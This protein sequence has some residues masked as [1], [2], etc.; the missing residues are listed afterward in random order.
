MIY[1]EDAPQ[2]EQL[3]YDL[4]VAIEQLEELHNHDCNI[5]SELTNVALKF[6]E[7]RIAIE[8]AR[9]KFQQ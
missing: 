9:K 2:K 6:D 4:K 3:I 1:Y 7:V 5:T 8:K